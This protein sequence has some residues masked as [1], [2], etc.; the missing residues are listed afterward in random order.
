[1]KLKECLELAST[2]GLKD[3]KEAYYNVYLHAGQMFEYDKIHEELLELSKD[4]RFHNLANA[5]RIYDV[6][7]E[8]ALNDYL[9]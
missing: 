1:M 8:E 2:C 3:L 7:I 5:K 4:L 6:S 9:C